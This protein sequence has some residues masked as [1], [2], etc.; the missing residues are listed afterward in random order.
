MRT[1]TLALGMMAAI[2]FS[3]QAALAALEKV[4][5]VG[6]AGK[7]LS[8]IDAEGNTRALKV[9]D[10][11]F[12]NDDITSKDAKAQLIFLDRS[13]LTVNAGTNVKIDTFVYNPETSQ[14]KLVLSSVKGAMRFVGGHLSKKE[15][16][17]IKTP[18]ATIG[19]RGGIVDTHVT[20]ATGATDSIFIY[21]E[22]MTMT[23][24]AGQTV[25]TTTFNTGFNLPDANAQPSALPPAVIQQHLGAFEPSGAASSN[26]PTQNDVGEGTGVNGSGDSSNSGGSSSG[27][28]SGDS[29]SPQS[30]TSTTPVTESAGT[31]S[32]TVTGNV[33]ET[34]RTDAVKQEVVNVVSG[35]TDATGNF[36]NASN[37][38][39][40]ETAINTARNNQGLP[41]LAGTAPVAP[42]QPVTA[43]PVAPV[44][45]APVVT[46]P[47]ASSSSTGGSSSSSGP[48]YTIRGRYFSMKDDVTV[49]SVYEPNEIVAGRIEANAGTTWDGT[50]NVSAYLGNTLDDGSSTPD[51]VVIP[52][53]WFSSGTV[54]VLDD[55]NHF[56]AAHILDGVNYAAG[57]EEFD[58]GVTYQSV[59]G[60]MNY[61]RFKDDTA[62]PSEINDRLRVDQGVFGE[63]VSTS[64]SLRTAIAQS[65]TL[66][67]NAAAESGILYYSFLPN[68]TG[69]VSA[70]NPGLYNY[71]SA[72]TSLVS[73]MDLPNNGNLGMTVDWNNKKFVSGY[74]NFLGN[75]T[76]NSWN[77]GGG[78]VNSF[79]RVSFGNF[80]E[81]GAGT[82]GAGGNPYAKGVLL[83][84]TGYGS[85]TLLSIVPQTKYG[86]VQVGHNIF[87]KSGTGID[88]F[89][90]DYQ[91]GDDNAFTSAVFDGN[92][93]AYNG[94]QAATRDDSQ[95][96]ANASV[97]DAARRNLGQ[98]MK[99]TAGGIM[100]SGPD[101][102]KAYS[103]Y[104]TD[105]GLVST[106]SVTADGRVN[107]NFQVRST[108]DYATAA[109]AT[110]S[111]QFGGPAQSAYISD[112][113]Y[114]SQMSGGSETQASFIASG[115]A[116]VNNNVP[117]CADCKFTHW[118]VWGGEFTV[119]SVD[120][121]PNLIPYVA[122]REATENLAAKVTTPT[123]YNSVNYEGNAYGNFV[124]DVN[125]TKTL[126]NRAGNMNAEADLGHRQLKALQ[127]SF[128][129]VGALSAT[130][131]EQNVATVPIEGSGHATFQ[132]DLS[133]MRVV[134][135]T[136]AALNAESNITGGFYGNTPTNVAKE[137]AGGFGVGFTDPMDTTKQIVGA[138]V[139]HG[140]AIPATPTP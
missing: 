31:S 80:N 93:V 139:Y 122:G 5:V 60:A 62:E 28:A 38:T 91:Q 106:L 85:G 68:I 40:L 95:Y 129:A 135:G 19:I 14:G 43:P 6:L 125:G 81:S 124:L 70:T 83:D 111:V 9:G 1:H 30:N 138:G 132:M 35:T 12:L 52:T 100:V 39:T 64:Y 55:T 24:G 76:L 75:D 45:G 3:G 66:K 17:T 133:Q 41:P 74:I 127:I 116:M 90:L 92:P 115:G 11:I 110:N 140:A 57:D 22:E 98:N 118:G 120:K 89:L 136:N 96:S 56:D 112:S 67:A 69:E 108:N 50:T 126:Y 44:A 77:T 82:V 99:V 97:A 87:A 72:A 20:G 102:S 25:S 71:N 53:A 34:S 119:G 47:P 49:N 79:A 37:N 131:I 134:Y 107:G 15:P 18:V 128:P 113:L 21:G 48:T 26:A 63:T 94:A 59:N 123:T 101:A 23:N 2:L 7:E 42:T 61:F 10:K 103:A 51:S 88:G 114:A 36:I 104:Q 4:G 117:Q 86:E 105:P 73:G 29:S 84:F 121:A 65:A 8:A 33:A 27:G 54:Q 130:L 58:S 32:N 16:V 13:T 46:T 109:G 78:N 137:V